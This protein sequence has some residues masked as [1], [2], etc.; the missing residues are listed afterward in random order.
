MSDKSGSKW[1]KAVQVFTAFFK[2]GILGYGGGPSSI[3]LVHQE[4]VKKYRWMNDGEFSDVLAL[5]NALP[6]PI[7]TKMAGYIGYRVLGITGCILGVLAMVLP[8]VLLMVLFLSLLSAYKASPKVQ[9]MTGAVTPVV[10]VMLAVLAYS[11]FKKSWEKKE[12]SVTVTVGLISAAAI[13][14]LDIHPAVII[15]GTLLFALFSKEKKPV[16]GEKEG[17]AS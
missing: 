14:L 5:G 8:T 3:P 16:T 4:V 13:G 6:G 2:V 12:K 10:G 17:K 1:K 15:G 7:A 9:G 11:F